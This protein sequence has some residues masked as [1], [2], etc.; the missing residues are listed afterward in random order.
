MTRDA[1]NALLAIVLTHLWENLGLYSPLIQGDLITI[2]STAMV[3]ATIYTRLIATLLYVWE[4][5]EA[6]QTEN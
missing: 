6:S 5:V 3:K 2:E 1:S 4:K